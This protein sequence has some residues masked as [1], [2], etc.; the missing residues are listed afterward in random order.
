M[1]FIFMPSGAHFSGKVCSRRRCSTLWLFHSTPDRAGEN[2]QRRFQ[3][4]KGKTIFS[5]H[6]TPEKYEKATMSRRP[7]ILDLC[8]ENH[9][10]PKLMNCG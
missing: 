8:Q 4:L 10:S 7:V 5:V 2:R 3:S 6:T 9:R 1:M